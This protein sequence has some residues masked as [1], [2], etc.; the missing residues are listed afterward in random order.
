MGVH[1][2][3]STH[4]VFSELR[5][6]NIQRLSNQRLPIE[7]VFHAGQPLFEF[8]TALFETPT[9]LRS[10]RVKL[11]PSLHRLKLQRIQRALHVYS[12]KRKETAINFP[13]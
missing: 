1:R 7:A 11:V 3:S 2:R 9:A 6:Q 8:S 10:Q 4:P 12:C 13:D 5:F